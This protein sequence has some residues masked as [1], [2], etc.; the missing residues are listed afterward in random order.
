MKKLTWK[1]ALVAAAMLI[2]PGAMV[3]VGA[4]LAYKA[5]K[6]KSS[7]NGKEKS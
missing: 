4:Y 3:T 6:D 7:A 1:H 2:V 5:C